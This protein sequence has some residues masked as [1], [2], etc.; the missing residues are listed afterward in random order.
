MNKERLSASADALRS[1]GAVAGLVCL[2]SISNKFS[3]GVVRFQEQRMEA[4]GRQFWST[5][6]G[7]S[8][9]WPPQAQGDGFCDESDPRFP[10]A[11]PAKCTLR[12]VVRD[13][14]KFP[15][16]WQLLAMGV[17]AFGGSRGP[18]LGL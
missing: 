5:N 17:P 1:D 6:K 7:D 4:A 12:V 9:S 2:T 11:W 3:I 8:A 18:C 16:E 14:S 13:P 10:A 15:K